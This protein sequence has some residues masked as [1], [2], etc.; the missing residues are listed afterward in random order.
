MLALQSLLAGENRLDP[1]ATRPAPF[2]PRAKSVIFL[3]MY[4]GPSQ[5]DTFDHK[6]A[7]EKWH[8]REIPVF[9]KEHA[10]FGET[11]ATAIRSPNT[12]DKYGQSG[13]DVPDK[14]P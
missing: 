6:P 3:F 12:V 11:K 1:L 9:K 4:G 14:N 2:A 8:G 13:N 5:V 7:L 10:F